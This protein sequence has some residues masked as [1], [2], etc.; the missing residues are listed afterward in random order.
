MPWGV[1]RSIGR[2]INS[3]Q[4]QVVLKTIFQRNLALL[5]PAIGWYVVGSYEYEGSSLFTSY[6]EIASVNSYVYNW[7]PM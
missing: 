6:L 3:A 5:K 2:L 4:H 1:K 7:C